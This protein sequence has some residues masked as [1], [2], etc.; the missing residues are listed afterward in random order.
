MKP[1]R[2]LPFFALLIVFA[3][4]GCATKPGTQWWRVGN[5][6]VLYDQ[7]KAEKQLIAV[8]QSCDIKRDTITAAG[9][10]K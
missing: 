8:G 4:A 6:L 1:R 2:A 7:T 9:D 10:L 5:C 3:L